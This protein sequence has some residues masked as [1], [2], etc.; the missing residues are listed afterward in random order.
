VN[1]PKFPVAHARTR[2]KPFGV[3]SFPVALSV[4][5]NGT[6]TIVQAISHTEVSVLAGSLS[7]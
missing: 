7:L 1:P 5:R 3:T 6:T 4:M 2:G